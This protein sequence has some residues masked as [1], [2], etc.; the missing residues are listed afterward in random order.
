MQGERDEGGKY[1]TPRLALILN[2]I[3]IYFY[4][5]KISRTFYI[6][7]FILLNFEN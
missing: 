6:Y 2:L 1:H 7:N 4:D 3:N 5:S